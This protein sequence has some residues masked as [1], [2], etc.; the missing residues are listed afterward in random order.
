MIKQ[1]AATSTGVSLHGVEVVDGG[2]VIVTMRVAVADPADRR[3]KRR[4]RSEFSSRQRGE[5]SRLARE[6]ENEDVR[7]AAGAVLKYA[8]G[9][10]YAECVADTHY[11]I[12]WV[13]G[14]L[15][16]YRNGGGSALVTR[17][18]RRSPNAGEAEHAPKQQE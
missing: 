2:K 13:R 4:P 7:R 1:T 8:R 11:G 17:N 10:P 3:A 16:A 5:L 9:A 14:L 15:E 18:Y 6:H 12:G